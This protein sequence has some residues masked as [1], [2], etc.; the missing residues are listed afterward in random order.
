MQAG[1]LNR[2]VTIESQGTTQDE[3]GG[4]SSGWTTV[5]EV[6]AAIAPKSGRELVAAKAAASEVSTTVSIRYRA[7][8][9]PAMRVNYGGKFYNITAVIDRDDAHKYLDLEC[10]TGLNNG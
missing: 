2:R 1:K 4:V 10:T 6:W 3:F 7:G 5:A 8:I 9:T